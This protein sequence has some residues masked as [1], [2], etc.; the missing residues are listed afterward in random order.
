MTR[1]EFLK[2]GDWW[3]VIAAYP[4][5][6]DDFI[7]EVIESE[8]NPTGL[9]DYTNQ[10]TEECI[11]YYGYLDDFNYNPDSEESEDEQYDY[12]YDSLYNSIEVS[13]VKIDEDVIDEYGL[14]WLNDKIA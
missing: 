6:R 9:N 11:E 14:E 2:D 13:A 1:E 5:V 7:A 8:D 4:T 12:W 3:L 10:L